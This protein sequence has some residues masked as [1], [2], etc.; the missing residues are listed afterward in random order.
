MIGKKNFLISISGIDGAGKTT[1]AKEVV[2][3]LREKGIKC[4][5][6]YG[7]L[8][9]LLSKPFILIGKKTLLGK[10]SSSDYETYILI[11]EDK[12]PKH[13]F[14]SKIYQ[15]ILLIDYILQAFFKIKIPVLLGRSIICDRYIYDTV[16]NDISMDVYFSSENITKII[17]KLLIFL[18]RP[19][20][21]FLIDISEEIAY[22]RKNDI[23]SMEYL[24]RRKKEYL[25]T[26]KKYNM[27]VLN[28]IKTI[29]ELKKEIEI[30]LVSD[31][32]I[33]LL[34]IVGS[35]FVSE[36]SI[37]PKTKEEGLELYTHAVKNKIGLTYLEAL[38]KKGIL[39]EFGLEKKYMEE[40]RK[41]DEQLKALK[42]VTDLF[43][44]HNV[45]Y[46]VFKSI[47]PFP[48]T[49]ND[50]DVIH[51]GSEE[52]YSKIR[53]IMLKSD[54]I[55]VKGEADADQCMFH[56][57][58]YGGYLQPHPKKKDVYDI[59]I[60]QSISAS[61]LKYMD[62][63][64]IEKYL[65]TVEVNDTQVKILKPEADLAL[66]IFHSIFPEMLFTLIAHYATLYYFL[67][68]NQDEIDNF[69]KF[70]RENHILFAVRAHLSIVGELH[71]ITHGFIPKKIEDTLKKIGNEKK[72]VKRCF[73]NDFKL[74]HRYGISTVAKILMEKL[75]ESTFR[76]SIPQQFIKMFDYK[77]VKWVCSE[78]IRRRKRETY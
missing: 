10:K 42:R 56:D 6:V 74:P 14:L 71:R 4:K 21:A 39:K 16:I 22:Q 47:M 7:R 66:I 40:K 63:K 23:P 78:L 15:G 27:I 51:F 64:K 1:L 20:A 50:I 37:L 52:E 35:P 12:I 69:I 17:N 60:Y 59:D 5:Y 2:K 3:S 19:D 13:P 46:A 70:A 72:E 18:P 49:P 8:K 57:I 75:N 38:N 31:E 53:D 61:Y 43:N 65:T 41:H 67:E 25:N 54:Y 36:E 48:A 68:I 44:L 77:I 73:R 26:A 24:K 58:K 9:P 34:Q 32:T 76:E 62:K 30:H 45:K 29:E 55:D 28:G 11:K 33:K